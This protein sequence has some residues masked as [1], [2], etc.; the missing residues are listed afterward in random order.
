MIFHTRKILLSAG[1]AAALAF[2][3]QAAT[4]H[5][6][7]GLDATRAAQASFAAADTPQ[8]AAASLESPR[9]GTWG[10]DMSG[11]DRSVKPGDDFYAFA[12]GKW[13]E[14]TEIPSDRTRFGNFDILAQLS[15]NRVHAILQEAAAGRLDDRDAARIGAAFTA[16]MDEAR[17]EKL[18]AK[19]IA[20]DLAKI[21]KVRTR[22]QFTALMG[23][24]NV[25]SVSSIL[26]VYVTI[27][28]KNPTRYAVGSTTAGLSLPDRDYYL[29]PA[30]AE[31]KAKYEAYVA[32]MLTMIGWPSP[33][34]N[35]KAVVAFET[36]L[37]EA[38]W[39]RAER[40][41]RDKTYTPM[42]PAE[43]NAA[44]PGFDWNRYLAAAGLPNV[45]R[46]VVAT[47]S[48][49][50]KFAGIYAAT[51]VET[52]KAWQAFRVADG[53][54]PY[55]SKRFVDA[56]FEFR[57]RTLMDQ[58]EQRPRWKRAVAF[59]NGV[60]GESVGRV[61]VARYF[62]P[63]SKAKMDELVANVRSAMQARIQKLHWM[64]PETKE[65]ALDKLAKFTV[66]IG[67]PEEW[68]DYSGL[69]LDPTDLYG[70]AIR[71]A[72][73]EWRRDVDRLDQP[74]DKREW[75]MTPQTV[76]AYYN[77]ANNEIV[78]PAAILQPPF[79]DPDA[80]PAI[81][82]GGIGGVIGHEISH[83]FDDQGRKSDGDGVLRDWWTAE[84]NTKF[85]AQAARLGAQYSEFEPL[86]GVRL[87]GALSMGENI[88]DMGGLSLGYDAYLA[89]LKGKPAPIVDGF[90]GQQRVFLGWA[91]VWRSKM[92]DEALR[93]Q[94]VTG[95]HSPPYYRVNGTIRNL[96]GWYEAFQIQPGDKLYVAPADRVDIW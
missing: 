38:S 89:S 94:V 1:G 6:H 7:D 22:D 16:F 58:P 80:D 91:Q 43:L 79:F 50:P 82:Y 8:G 83:G 70:N 3:A 78:F 10:F 69:R 44:T 14:R 35:A 54:A 51:P 74:V 86:P 65:R 27:D 76:N 12:N 63:E 24:A 62:P 96:P 29:L 28:A 47:D 61:Y 87:N 42:S 95:P 15:E 9:F 93:Q 2:A 17:V 11:M 48:A 77:F 36:R 41:D 53:A 92:R 81:N 75:G 72:A 56:N 66:K 88:G 25:S 85:Q 5:E 67:Y 57:N 40:R 13:A 18:D 20:G 55:L 19:P 49:Y 21:R 26:P 37:A 64:G 59:T 32:Q 31:K 4:A 23:R 60:I 73:Y 30:F 45:D 39:T 71:S 84:D 52:L 34:D 68:R 33:A 46:I 90:T